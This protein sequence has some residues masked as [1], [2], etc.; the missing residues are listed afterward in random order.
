MNERTNELLSL[1]DAVTT[2]PVVII[3]VKVKLKNQSGAPLLIG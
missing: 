1:A 2:V 3:K